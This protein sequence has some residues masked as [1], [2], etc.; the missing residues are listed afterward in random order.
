MS[1]DDRRILR[2]TPGMIFYKIDQGLPTKRTWWIFRGA[3]SEGLVGPPYITLEPIEDSENPDNLAAEIIRPHRRRKE[4][5]MSSEQLRTS[6]GS[7][8]PRHYFLAYTP[9]NSRR[10]NAYVSVLYDVSCR[11]Y[12]PG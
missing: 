11:Q 1:A 6:R 10:A 9:R 12:A 5:S 3:L 4:R 7:G 2:P 8:R